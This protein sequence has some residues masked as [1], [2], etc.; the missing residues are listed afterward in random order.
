MR[1]FFFLLVMASFVSCKKAEFRSCVKSA[2][3]EREREVLLEPYTTM[4]LREK[5]KYVLV[6]DTVE[7][8]ILKGG[9]NLLNFIECKVTDGQLEI[10][11]LNQC[12]FLRSYKHK[13]TAEIHFKDLINIRFEGT[14]PMTN[15]GTLNVGWLTFLIRD[16]AGPVNLKLNAEAIFAGISHGWGDFTFSGEVGYM[17][18]NI[19]SNGYCDTYGMKVRDSL[20][21]ISN[22]PGLVKVNA[23][24]VPLVAELSGSGDIWYKGNTLGA[25]IVYQ[26]STGKLIKKD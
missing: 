25:P 21:V 5:V 8:V 10:S 19:R 16:G 20:T 24:Q 26:Y 12:A 13:V 2:G 3:E 4:F 9:K 14:E 15:V 17:N 1:T 18:L 23:D 7:K 6:Q 22:T 11:N